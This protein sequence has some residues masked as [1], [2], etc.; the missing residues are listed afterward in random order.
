M[1]RKTLLARVGF[2]EFER[3]PYHRI[4]VVKD[5]RE[6]TKTLRCT[7]GGTLQ[8]F[9]PRMPGPV[10]DRACSHIRFLFDPSD[11]WTTKLRR[12]VL[13]LTEAGHLAFDWRY[14]ERAIL[15]SP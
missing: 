5:R 3:E 8:K 12:A 11:P 10:F 9:S 2:S 14:A 13:E 1:A 15:E 6:Q 4:T 7:C